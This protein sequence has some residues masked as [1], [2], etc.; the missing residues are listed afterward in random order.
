MDSGVKVNDLTEDHSMPSRSPSIGS[1]PDHKYERNAF[2]VHSDASHG[3]ANSSPA[4]KYGPDAFAPLSGYDSDSETSLSNQ[5][6]R[7]TFT[8]YPD[9]DKS[10]SPTPADHFGPEAFTFGLHNARAVEGDEA[11]FAAE[12]VM[13]SDEDSQAFGREAFEV[14]LEDSGDNDSEEMSDCRVFG[15]EAFQ[16]TASDND[17]ES[18]PNDEVFG[19]EAYELPRPVDVATPTPGMP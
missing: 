17:G 9:D 5:F 4:G 11:K 6:G 2:I 3:S 15:P 12:H 13:S 8:I 16:P 10:A 7:A 18:S 14:E 19:P 1:T